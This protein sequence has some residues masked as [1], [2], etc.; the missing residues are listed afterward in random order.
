MGRGPLGRR[1]K[2]EGKRVMQLL[3]GETLTLEQQNS[4]WVA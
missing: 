2:E 4:R 1:E 3:A